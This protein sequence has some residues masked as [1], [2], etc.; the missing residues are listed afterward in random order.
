LSPQEERP[1]D[2]YLGNLQFDPTMVGYFYK[3]GPFKLD[4]S[5][6]GN[7]NVGHEFRGNGKELGNGVIGREL[8]VNERWA[9]V[10]YLKTL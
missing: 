4:V 8:S 6:K 5:K 1:T 2:V 9:L 7:L 3:A 10:E